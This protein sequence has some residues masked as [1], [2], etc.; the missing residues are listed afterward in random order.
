MN[1]LNDEIA[2]TKDNI[3]QLRKKRRIAGRTI[4]EH[5]ENLMQL[6]QLMRQRE[7]KMQELQKEREAITIQINESNQFLKDEIACRKKAQYLVRKHDDL[8]LDAE[9]SPNSAQVWL[10]EWKENM[11]YLN[12]W[13]DVLAEAKSLVSTIER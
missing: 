3:L 12:T 8:H 13:Q 4:R 10:G 11:E 5:E 2:V 7:I 1:P 6:E 9:A